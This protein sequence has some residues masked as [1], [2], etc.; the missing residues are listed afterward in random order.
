M[1]LHRVK[2][3]NVL[4]FPHQAS[5][6]SFAGVVF[7][8]GEKAMTNTLIGPNGSGKS[9]FLD[10]VSQ[11]FKAWLFV[12]YVYHKDVIGH[13]TTLDRTITT[14]AIRLEHLEKHFLYPDR[15]SQVSIEIVF[16]NNDYDNLFFLC[17][18]RETINAL[19]QKYS[20][21]RIQFADVPYESLLFYNRLS[22]DFTIDVQWQKAILRKKKLS[23]EQKFLLDYLQHIELIQ[24]C[25]SIYNDYERK[26]TERKWYP[27]KNTFA[28][29]SSQR[30]RALSSLA[31]DISAMRIDTKAVL[32]AKDTAK[33]DSTIGYKL[34]LSKILHQIKY[35]QEQ[36]SM[37]MQSCIDE[38]FSR[39][40]YIAWL[41]ST[42]L[43]YLWYSL[44][45][46]YED[47]MF[48][49]GLVDR[50]WQHYYDFSML[51]SGEQSFLLIVMSLYGYDMENGLMIIDEPELHLHPQMQKQFIDMIDAMSEKLK[52]QFIVAT[53]SPVMINE[54]NIGHVY[55]CT[56]INNGTYIHNPPYKYLWTDEA[57][58]IHMLKFGNVAKIFFVDTI[59]MVEW[60]TDA[61]FFDYYLQYISQLVPWWHMIENYE[62]ININGKW[63]YRKWEK[64]LS[65]F[66]LHISFLGDWDNVLDRGIVKLQDFTDKMDALRR[67]QHLKKVQ[68]YGKLVSLISEEFPDQHAHIDERIDAL[69]DKH[70]FILKKGDLETYLGLPIKWLDEVV[71]F[72]H[73]RFASWYADARYDSFRDELDAIFYRIFSPNS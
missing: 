28:L 13:T 65:K 20:R 12:D 17:K 50:S 63:S 53:H 3:S 4:S 70:I 58:L 9:N 52:M 14:N 68:R 49:F 8:T 22:L 59:I 36:C 62:I 51:S 23:A 57:N 35:A 56:K 6:A 41:N 42:L 19:I 10:I 54:K 34:C 32:L 67:N 7:D 71:H 38:A 55:K 16:N 72:C 18:Y 37:D 66:G 60:E 1:Q 73:H 25:M 61:Y 24:I 48:Y 45:A 31:E 47:E 30:T 11:V 69:Y 39:N 15:R 43:R 5:F 46:E 33:A 44:Q 64:F 40:S 2:I 27:L 26:E 29:L 21:M